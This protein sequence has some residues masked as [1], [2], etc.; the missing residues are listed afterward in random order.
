MNTARLIVGPILS[1]IF[2]VIFVFVF[3]GAHGSFKPIQESSLASISE[4]IKVEQKDIEEKVIEKDNEII[5]PK[6]PAEDN[7]NLKEIYEEINA[8]ASFSLITDLKGKEKIVFNRF[9]SKN[10]PIASLTKLMTAIIVLDNYNLQ[11]TWRISESAE[12]K[13]RNHEDIEVGTELTVKDFLNLMLV[14]SSNKSAYALAE[15]TSERKFVD[16]MNQKAQEIGLENTVFADPSGLSPENISTAKDLAK[17]TKY[18]LRNY[19]RICKITQRNQIDIEGIGRII[20]TSQLVRE[21]PETVCS[22]TGFTKVAKGCLIFVKKDLENNTYS[23]NIILGAED[24]Y[25]EMKKLLKKNK[26]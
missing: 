13:S 9:A 18:I 17:L 15:M 12:L 23:I 26:E 22:K 4:V 14:A 8:K 24:R 19:S 7:N 6:D 20:N 21:I 3:V 16:L 11:E 5:I 1:V 10:L 25:S 2:V